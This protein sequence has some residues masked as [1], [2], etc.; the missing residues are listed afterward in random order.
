MK[1]TFFLLWVVLL[2]TSCSVKA[3]TQEDVQTNTW[4]VAT[5]TD[6]T[7]MTNEGNEADVNPMKESLSESPR[8]QEWVEIDNNGKTVHA[9]VVYPENKENS[10]AVVMIHENKGLNDWARNMADQVAAEWHIVIAP[11]LLSSFDDTR[12]KTSDFATDD[13]ATQALYSLSQETISSDLAAVTKYAKSLE[14]FNGNLVSAG[15]CWGGSQSFRLANQK[16][17]FKASLVFYGTAPEEEEFYE[18]VAVPV[19]GFYAENDDRVNATIEKTETEMQKNEKTFEYE[20]YDGVGHAF[21]R[22]ADTDETDELSIE[23]KNIAFER[24]KEILWEYK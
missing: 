17:D 4:D 9:F 15:F 16:D 21:M 6:A 14:S 24:M 12:V 11:D 22:K 3:P 8:H 1:N 18:D 23:A 13:D 10:S 20:Y 7:V 2:F 19:Y 5:I